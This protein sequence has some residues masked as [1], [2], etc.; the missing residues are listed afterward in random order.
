MK[1][2][3]MY[4]L[5]G[6]L[7]EDVG[8]VV[9]LTAGH[10]CRSW[11]PIGPAEMEIKSLDSHQPLLS[12]THLH[13]Q[14]TLEC[15]VCYIN[16]SIISGVTQSEGY[17]RCYIFRSRELDTTCKFHCFNCWDLHRDA[18]QCNITPHV[19]LFWLNLEHWSHMQLHIVKH[20]QNK[21]WELNLSLLRAFLNTK[22]AEISHLKCWVIWKW[23]LRHSDHVNNAKPGIT[24]TFSRCNYITKHLGITIIT[25]CAWRFSI[26]LPHPY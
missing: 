2:L 17:G 26:I 1:P 21:A 5:A 4:L 3:V 15:Y 13:I 14:M 6:E 18:F 9:G 19:L 12:V 10:E 20:A 23:G 22:P 8:D 25:D 24:G 7:A 16:Y 11:G